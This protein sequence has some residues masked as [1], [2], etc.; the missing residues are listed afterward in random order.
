MQNGRR[1]TKARIH[2]LN[3]PAAAR[4]HRS[5]R[6][7]GLLA[8]KTAAMP[9]M[10]PHKNANS[11]N[12]GPPAS[13]GQNGSPFNICSI[14]CRI[15][16]GIAGHVNDGHGRYGGR[17]LADP[18]KA[19]IGSARTA[20]RLMRAARHSRSRRPCSLASA[21]SRRS[22]WASARGGWQA[23][24]AQSFA[25]YVKIIPASVVSASRRR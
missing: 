20:A 13:A 17:P 24:C 7:P 6:L 14:N 25:T 10:R 15:A 19:E 9:S 12:Q 22:T 21:K 1:Q 3:R 5:V 2:W 23:F 16:L 8:L 4:R 11:L 18:M